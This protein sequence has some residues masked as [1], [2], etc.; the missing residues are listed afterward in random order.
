LL[1]DDKFVIYEDTNNAMPTKI[2]QI[3]CYYYKKHLRLGSVTTKWHGSSDLENAIQIAKK[4]SEKYT[5]GWR[6]AGC[7]FR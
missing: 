4:I 6:K 1:I 2:H 5:T 7:C 3:S